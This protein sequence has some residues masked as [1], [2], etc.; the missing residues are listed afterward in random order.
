M[1]PYSPQ[2]ESLIS[3]FSK[4]P[5]IGRKTAEKFVFY[6]VKQG[7]QSIED[8]ISSL[9]EF[10]KNLNFCPHCF[11]LTNTAG[12]CRICSDK[13][14]NQQLICVVEELHD[15][16]VIESIGKYTGVYHVLGGQLN[17][18]DGITADK[19]H[20]KE[21]LE[22]IKQEKTQEIILALNP[23]M[24]GESTAIALKRGLQPFGVKITQ[25]ARGLPM[26]ADLEYA[27]EVTLTN[28]LKN[29]EII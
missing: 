2:L 4:L 7:K 6:L 26:G 14:R 24:Q 27:D 10:E 13:S 9:Q 28:A 21:L 25:L 22:R 15:L 11:N 23:N 19:L 12:Q 16:N 3:Q 8:L 1:L 29:R 20:F 5:G 18:L 17:P